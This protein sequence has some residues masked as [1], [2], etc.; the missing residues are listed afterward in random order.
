[1][2]EW[3]GG[4]ST[5]RFD[6]ALAQTALVASWSAAKPEK[7][8]FW[9]YVNTCD[10]TELSEAEA[11]QQTKNFLSI[12]C[13]LPP[14]PPPRKIRNVRKIFGF[15]SRDRRERTRRASLI[16]RVQ[17]KIHSNFVQYTPPILAEGAGFELA[18]PLRALQISSLAH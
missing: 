2:R 7:A 13:R 17:F 5:M 16:I 3:E 10:L 1:M 14:H 18:V 8:K 15:C 4:S 9:E 11:A 12:F 6:C